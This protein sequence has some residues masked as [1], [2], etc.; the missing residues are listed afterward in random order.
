MS[1]NKSKQRRMF[2]DTII[3]ASDISDEL[4]DEILNISQDAIENNELERDI[5]SS[6][7]KQLDTRYGTTWNVIVGKNFGSYV[8]HEKGHF[9]YF[10][11][12]PL[13]FLIFK[14]P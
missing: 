8:T 12:G 9:L 4:K 7:K 1:D 13:A 3:K 11:I 14:T 5:A 2:K 6:I 10:Y